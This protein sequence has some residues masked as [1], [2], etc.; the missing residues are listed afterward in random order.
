M[1]CEVLIGRALHNVSKGLRSFDTLGTSCPT[2]P[3]TITFQTTC[4]SNILKHTRIIN[5]RALQLCD[6]LSLTPNS[7]LK[8]NMDANNYSQSNIHVRCEDGNYDA[9]IISTVPSILCY[10]DKCNHFRHGHLCTLWR[11][12]KPRS[13]YLCFHKGS[14]WQNLVWQHGIPRSL[15]W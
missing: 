8:T 12:I 13:K 1:G 15:R 9:S 3:H 10:I 2:K 5:A 14:F 6:A 4:T 7:H 11:G